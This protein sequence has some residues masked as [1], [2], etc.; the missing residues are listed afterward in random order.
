M[1]IEP[2]RRALAPAA[3]IFLGLLHEEADGL[4]TLWRQGGHQ[5]S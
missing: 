3:E 5:E 2:A 4:S 1:L